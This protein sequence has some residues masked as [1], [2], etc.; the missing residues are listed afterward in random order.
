MDFATLQAYFTQGYGFLLIG[1]IAL[2]V[3][4]IAIKVT[5]KEPSDVPDAPD[6]RWWRADRQIVTQYDV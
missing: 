1:S 4:A 2:L 6:L 5:R 3:I